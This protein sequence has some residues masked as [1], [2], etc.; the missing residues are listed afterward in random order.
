MRNIAED[1]KIAILQPPQ[2]NVSNDIN[3]Y[4]E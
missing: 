4:F 1:G 3:Q 2:L